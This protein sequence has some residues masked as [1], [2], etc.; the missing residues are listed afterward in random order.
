MQLL[1]GLAWLSF[2]AGHSV[3]AGRGGKALFARWFGRRSRLAYNGVAVAHLVLA[4][5]IGLLVTLELLRRR[6]ARLRGG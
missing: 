6:S 5:S 2:G 4:V 1:Y 3:L